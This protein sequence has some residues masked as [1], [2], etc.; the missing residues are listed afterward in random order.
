M[1]RRY[2]DCVVIERIKL[3]YSLRKKGGLEGAK[4]AVIQF[5][6]RLAHAITAHKVQGQSIPS[7]LKVG[8]DI[9]SVF[10]AAQAYVMLSRVQSI[11]QVYIANNIDEKKLMFAEKAL[12]ELNRL[13]AEAESMR[14]WEA[15]DSNSNAIFKIA[16]LNCA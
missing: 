11:D 7:P 8:M 12:D 6:I 14:R 13:Q 1:A 16:T 5:P 2:P 3:E 9:G 15:W 10:E 4:A